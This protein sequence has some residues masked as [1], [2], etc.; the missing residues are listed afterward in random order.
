M[1]QKQILERLLAVKPSERQLAWQEMEYYNFIH[2]SI[3]TFYGKE[4]SDGTLDPK[5]FYPKKL[6][7]D[8]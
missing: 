4:W 3:N 8:Q 2:F 7:T 1:N 6:N 5:R